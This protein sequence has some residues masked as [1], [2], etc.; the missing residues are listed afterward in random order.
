MRREPHLAFDDIL[1]VLADVNETSY[2]DTGLSLETSYVY[3]VT[4]VNTAG[5]DA[6]SLEHTIRPINSPP[7]EIRSLEFDSHHASAEPKWSPYIAASFAS[8]RVMRREPGLES[9]PVA[10]ISVKTDTVFTDLELR[11]NTEFSYSV[12]VMTSGGHSIANVE[13]SGLIHRFLGEWSLG[14]P[15]IPGGRTGGGGVARLYAENR[16]S[17]Q[18]PFDFGVVGSA[19]VYGSLT[20]SIAVDDEGLIYVAD[21]LNN[22]IQQFAQSGSRTE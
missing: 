6:E 2:V 18:A 4:N 19:D 15:G 22:R 9:E 13:Q 3:R 20:G 10:V 1:A 21:V 8:Y 5:L 16:S 12:E 14:I 11:G 7:V 17:A